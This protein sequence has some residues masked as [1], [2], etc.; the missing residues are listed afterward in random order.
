MEKKE[1]KF[2]EGKPR[3]GGRDYTWGSLEFIGTEEI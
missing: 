1:V 3:N 2:R